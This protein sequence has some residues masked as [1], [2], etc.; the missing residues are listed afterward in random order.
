M[1]F[2]HS[3]NSFFGLTDAGSTQR[4]FSAYSNKE[5]L[6]RT[7]DK[8]E[9]TVLGAAGAAKTYLPG[10]IDGTIT[11]GGPWDPTMIGYLNGLVGLVTTWEYGPEGNTA[12]TGYPKYTGSCF[13][14]SYSQSSDVTAAVAWEATLQITGAVTVGTY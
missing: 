8:A 13:I 1:P 12:S 11:L 7:I 14:D 5:A 6:A 4:N 3:K 2:T 9:T 10:F